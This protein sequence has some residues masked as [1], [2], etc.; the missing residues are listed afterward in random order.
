MMKSSGENRGWIFISIPY[1]FV[2]GSIRRLIALE[3]LVD[4]QGT[5]GSNYGMVAR[6]LMIVDN[7]SLEISM[8]AFGISK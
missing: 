1:V 6:S 4:A 8:D 5:S 3:S 7:L 2:A